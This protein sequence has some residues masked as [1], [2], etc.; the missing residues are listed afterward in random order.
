MKAEIV[1]PFIE[2]VHEVFATMLG[3][4]A[5]RGEVSVSREST[6]RGDLLSIIGISGDTKGTVAMSMPKQTA[7]NLV[8]AITGLE[9]H[10]LDE[11]VVDGVAEFTNM[12]AGGAK[13]K[14]NTNGRPPMDLGLPSV[15]T[16]SNF[17]VD[18]PKKSIW[19]EVPFDSEHGDFVL[20]V[21]FES[22]GNG[23]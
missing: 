12:V 2:S 19:L 10:E 8:G 1:N 9:F 17:S 21:T 7:L 5:T 16:G 23:N 22:A 6:G 18:Y 14:L 15:V 13:A 4:E 20:R 11:T 3:I